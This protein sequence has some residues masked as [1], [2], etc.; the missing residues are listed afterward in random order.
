M[1]IRT[2]ELY[3]GP[4][5]EIAYLNLEYVYTDSP[6]NVMISDSLSIVIIL[7]RNLDNSFLAHFDSC[8]TQMTLSDGTVISYYE[9]A[10]STM[11]VESL[12]KFE[13]DGYRYFVEYNYLP[14]E[15]NLNGRAIRAQMTAWLGL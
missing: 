7:D 6:L 2:S 5:N 8:K 3:L 1:K 14:E 15:A 13:R 9:P 12:I 4:K 10:N 11:I